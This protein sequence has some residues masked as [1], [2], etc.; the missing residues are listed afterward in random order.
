MVSLLLIGVSSETRFLVDDEFK[1]ASIEK[2]D[3][4]ETLNSFI[5]RESAVLSEETEDALEEK[6]SLSRSK[7]LDDSAFIPMKRPSTLCSVK[8]ED[9]LEFKDGSME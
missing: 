5:R 4:V 1:Y 6:R 7:L 9:K 8:T 3:S 2:A